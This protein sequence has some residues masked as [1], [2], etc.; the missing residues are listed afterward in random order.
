M[1]VIMNR[2]KGLLLLLAGLGVVL[3][4]T[5]CQ[6]SWEFSLVGLGEDEILVDYQVWEE[7]AE[8]GDGKNVSLEQILYGKGARVITE[9]MIWNDAGEAMSI[10]WEDAAETLF[11]TKKGKLTCPG[12][13]LSPSRLEIVLSPWEDQVQIGIIDI[14]PTAAAALGIPAPTLST[15]QA[16]EMEPASSVLLLFLDGFGYFRYQ[17]SL[18]EGLIPE[19][20]KL[21]PPLIGL[22]TYP[23]ITTVST[24]SLL[25]GTEPPIHGVEL[26]GI[27]KTEQETLLDAAAEV[28]LKVVAVEG[29]ALAFN[30]RGAELTLSGDRDGNGG[31]DDNVLSNALAFL[32]DGMPDLFYLHFHGIDDQG[33][34]VGPGGL[35]EK[36]KIREVDAAVGQ[37]LDQLPV[38]TLVI[39]FAD[40]GMH[41]VDEE[42]RIGNH[43]NLIERD[44]LIPVWIINIESSQ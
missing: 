18:A 39:I 38:G 41:L 20:A 24:A 25:T 10:S 23:P 21:D 6:P 9:I 31:T 2:M 22:T 40:H 29:E 19:L 4:G 44:M 14:A 30:L 43:G 12:G 13:D 34:E 5:G 1:G 11:L 33:H 3:L 35:A 27:R 15:G 16:W 36:D 32:E 26:R 8:F 37:V 7:Y 42:G 17:E 28:G